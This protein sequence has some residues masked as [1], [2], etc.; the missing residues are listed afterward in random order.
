MPVVSVQLKTLLL[1]CLPLSLN[2]LKNITQN[3]A[4]EKAV[5]SSANPGDVLE[6]TLTTNNSRASEITNYAISY[7]IGDLLDYAELDASYL[8]SAGRSSLR[9]RKKILRGRANFA[10]KPGNNKVFQGQS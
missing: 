5:Q 3:L 4:G 9:I 1:K 6:Y 10:S 8:G 7:Y 2:E